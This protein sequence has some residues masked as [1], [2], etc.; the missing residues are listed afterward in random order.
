MGR[1]IRVIS[2]PLKGVGGKISFSD[3]FVEGWGVVMGIVCFYPE[4]LL[5]SFHRK[6]QST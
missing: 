2:S 1:V 3:C 4:K 5:D 6:I